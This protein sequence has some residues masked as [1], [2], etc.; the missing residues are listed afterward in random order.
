MILLLVGS[1]FLLLALAVPVAFALG[2][3]TL[4]VILQGGRFPTEVV[5]QRAISGVGS[6]PM[7][8][9]PLFILAGYLMEYGSTTRLMAFANALLGR[10][11]GGLA[12]A[13]VSASAMFGAVSGSG[14][15]TIAA[16][17]G[18]FGPEMVRRKYPKGF[19]VSLLAASGG[20]GVLIPPSVPL[21]VYGLIGNVSIGAL[22]F[23]T[24]IPGLIT[25]LLIAATSMLL[26]WW[27]GFGE[28]QSTGGRELWAAF[29]QAVP[30]LLLPVI[31]LGGILTGVFTATESAAAGVVFAGLLAGLIYREL[32]LARIYDALVKTALTSS[33][34]L[35]VLAVSASFAWVVTISQ[36]PVLVASW[37]RGISE[38]P[39]VIFIIIQLIFLVLG[40]VMES[41]PIIIITTPVFL[42]IAIAVGVDPV[43]YGIVLTMNIVV[44][45]MSP[46]VATSIYVAARIVKAR[47]ADANIWLLAFI[48]PLIVSGAL[49]MVFP[50]I[51]LFLPRL[52]E[53]M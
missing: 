30:P 24:I 35:I 9:L 53:A 29:L 8:A 22:F 5:I 28:R 38:S 39:I 18:V 6:F 36:F 45:A 48:L 2:I 32:T 26:A 42:P 11:P 25:T 52:L 13:S 40:I 31:I 37:L 47:P 7:L 50:E 17:G 20:L 44:A 10:L 14:I 33:V 12:I 34:I 16:I 1:L 3:S 49:C 27:F 23:G 4:L 19:V 41:M 21:I 15:A 43:V 51:V 46:P